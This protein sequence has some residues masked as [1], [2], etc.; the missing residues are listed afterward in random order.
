MIVGIDASNLKVG[1]GKTHLFEI[2]TNFKSNKHNIKKFVI[3]GQKKNLENI[4]HLPFVNLKAPKELEKNFLIRY[5]WQWYKLPKD[6]YFEKCD[7][8]FVPGGLFSG[9]FIPSLVMCRNMLPFE[10]K[11]LRR[12]GFSFVM[13]PSLTPKP[14]AIKTT[15]GLLAVIFLAMDTTFTIEPSLMI[16]IYLYCAFFAS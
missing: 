14:P 8:L 15:G 10:W 1:G 11:E 16:G 4:K 13:L 2:L 5:Y 7:I 3:W 12:F 9:K 6:A